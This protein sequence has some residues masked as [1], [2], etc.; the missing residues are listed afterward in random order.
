VATQC[1][2]WTLKSPQEHYLEAKKSKFY[3]FAW[4]VTSSAAAREVIAANSVPSASHNCSAYLISSTVT[5]CT[6]DGE[7][8]GSAGRPILSAIEAEG[9]QVRSAHACSACI[10][11]FYCYSQSSTAAHTQ[12][13][14]GGDAQSPFLNCCSHLCMMTGCFCLAGSGSAGGAILWGH[15]T[16]HR[17]PGPCLRRSSQAVSTRGTTR[18]CSCAGVLLPD[19]RQ[20]HDCFCAYHI[21]FIN[22]LRCTEQPH[23]CLREHV[24]STCCNGHLF[25]RFQ[26][27]KPTWLQHAV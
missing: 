18:V 21:E 19:T 23:R 24:R 26:E 2:H 20:Q 7:P 6:D 27:S 17:R 3:A 5:H 25:Q 1:R 4:P 22:P 12:C 9:L 15:E 14:P 13:A 16:G 10:V 11:C 8:S